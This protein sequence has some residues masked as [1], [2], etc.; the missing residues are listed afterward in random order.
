MSGDEQLLHH[1][2]QVYGRYPPQG[3]GQLYIVVCLAGYGH[4]ARGGDQAAVA[5]SG[6]EGVGEE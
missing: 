5:L 2:H 6:E 4:D 3:P 1:T